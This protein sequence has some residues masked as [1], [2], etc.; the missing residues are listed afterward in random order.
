M[1]NKKLLSTIVATALVTTTMAMPVMAAEGGNFNIDVSTKTG[2]IRVQVPTSMAM[3]VDQ[4]EITHTGSQIAAGEFEMTNMSEMDVKV[5]ITSTATLGSGI[6]LASTAAGID[7]EKDEVWLGV[8]AMTNDGSSNTGKKYDD[9]GTADK[10][11]EFWELTDTNSNVTTFA[12]DTKKA[13]QTFYL[14]KGTGQATY[15]LA[16][17]SDNTANA[18]YKK[19]TY[20]Q[21]YKLTEDTSIDSDATLQA[22]VKNQDVYVVATSAV[23]THDSPV[24]KVDVSNVA[25]NT[26][27][28]TNTYYTAADT[29]TEPTGSDV[30]VY[31]VM[32]T[33]GGKAGFTYVGKLSPHKESWSDTDIS[34]VNVK[35]EIGGVTGTR[36]DE[37]KDDCTYGLYQESSYVSTNTI[38]TSSNTVTLSLPADV[39]LSKVELTYEDGTGTIALANGS[40][41]TLNGSTLTVPAENITAWLGLSPAYTKLVLTFSDDTS[42]TITMQ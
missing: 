12:K 42:E 16:V 32:A 15:K 13:E 24:T 29:A 38:S 1:R 17:P 7:A 34:T 20:A 10:T 11:E 19:E 37:V 22:A 14:A 6:S 18:G 40:Q 33:A 30:Y 35:Y 4:F 39:T 5:G 25:S 26:Y 41:Y 21:Y 23:S 9:V 28:N 36:Y 31:G 2:I 8:A 3:A 27:A